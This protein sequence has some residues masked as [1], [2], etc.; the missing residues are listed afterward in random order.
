MFCA[1]L[2]P[3]TLETVDDAE[4]RALVERLAVSQMELVDLVAV[5]DRLITTIVDLD[6]DRA[7]MKRVLLWLRDWMSRNRDAIK[8]EF[9]R[10]SRYTPGFLDAY[11]VNRFVDGSPPSSMRQPKIPSI[12]FGARSTR[13]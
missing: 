12:R 10:A 7:M 11:I 9:G 5:V 4:V 3:P 13:R 6:L 8:V 1:T 2:F